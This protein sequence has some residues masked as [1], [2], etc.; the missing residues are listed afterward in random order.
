MHMVVVSAQSSLLCSVASPQHIA[1]ASQTRTI[2]LDAHRSRHRLGERSARRRHSGST[3]PLSG[4]IRWA[5][6]G[7]AIF[8]SSFSTLFC[9]AWVILGCRLGGLGH[10]WKRCKKTFRVLPGRLLTNRCAQCRR[11][12]AARQVQ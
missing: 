7:S 11:N 5:G 4:R 6:I 8:S 9:P 2:D 10:F 3:T 12:W 1:H